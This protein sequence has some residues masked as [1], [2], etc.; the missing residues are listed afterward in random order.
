M[1]PRRPAATQEQIAAMLRDGATYEEIRSTLH[2]GSGSI[3]LVRATLDLEPGPNQTQRLTPDE[4]R[5]AAER[6]YPQVAAMLRDGATYR[7]ITAATG[8]N[9][10]TITRVRRVLGIPAQPASRRPRT[11]AQTIAQHLDTHD[12]GHA[13]WTGPRAGMLPILWAGGRRYNARHAVFKAHH[14]RTP[15]GLVT[16]TCNQPE[17]LAGAHLVDERLRHAEQ[18]LDEQFAAIFG[19]DAS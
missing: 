16:R 11:I 9:V 4:Q 8:T 1:S 19:P 5:A 12:D 15:E 2:V 13:F 3:A 10:H 14:G 17:C 7:E 6:R 18:L